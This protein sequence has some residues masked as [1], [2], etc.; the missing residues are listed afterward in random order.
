V[1]EELHRGLDLEIAGAGS[2]VRV[3]ALCPGFTI[4][5]FATMHGDESRGHPGMLWMRAGDVVD[6]S[7]RGLERGRPLSS[8][9]AA[10]YKLIVALEKLALAPCVQRRWYGRAPRAPLERSVESHIPQLQA[11]ADVRAW[12][13]RESRRR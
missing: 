10:I 7:L 3:Q 2:P 11:G 5:G 4:T 8:G 1:D 9:P 6:A 12:G 13:V